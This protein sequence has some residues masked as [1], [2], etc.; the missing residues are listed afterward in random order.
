[1]EIAEIQFK[2]QRKEIFRNSRALYLKTGNFCIV[3]ADRGE[4]MGLIISLAQVGDSGVNEGHPAIG[5]VAQPIQNVGVED[6]D[7]MH[8]PACRQ[9]VIK[10]RVVVQ[11]QVAAEPD[12]GAFVGGEFRH[13]HRA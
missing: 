2:A 13:F 1:M 6:K 5:A 11:A 3:Q 9:R 4:D 8:R 12:Q 7:A 10:R